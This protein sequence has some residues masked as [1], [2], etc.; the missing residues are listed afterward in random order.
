MSTQE[1]TSGVSHYEPS[2]KS[3]LSSTK[4]DPD[5]IKQCFW[6]LKAEY[7]AYGKKIA[8]WSVLGFAFICLFELLNR[9]LVGQVSFSGIEIRRLSFL[10]YIMPPLVALS[11]LNLATFNVEENIYIGVLKE[12]ALQEFPELRK[13]E[14]L[15]LFLAQQGTFGAFISDSFSKP[16]IARSLKVNRTAQILIIPVSFLGF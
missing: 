11:G 2:V 14:I 9:R 5:F 10:L 16:L 1:Q 15:D 7:D 6:N 3:L 8:L 4:K 13:S 12:F